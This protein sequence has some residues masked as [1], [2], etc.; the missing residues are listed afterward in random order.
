[1]P[2]LMTSLMMSAL[3]M[4]SGDM[5]PLYATKTN[6]ITSFEMGFLLE[7]FSDLPGQAIQISTAVHTRWLSKLNCQWQATRGGPVGFSRHPSDLS[8]SNFFDS[9]LRCAAYAVMDDQTKEKHFHRR[10]A[11]NHPTDW[12][13]NY[14]EKTGKCLIAPGRARDDLSGGSKNVAA[15]KSVPEAVFNKM[16]LQRKE[17]DEHGKALDETKAAK[18]E[19]K[20]RVLSKKKCIT[21]PKG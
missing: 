2:S 20:K 4:L 6:N 7:C 13:C 18:A 8:H 19:L 21:L 17:N 9:F 15:C 1:M 12:T 14:C 16:L 10:D 5:S 11:V 3:M